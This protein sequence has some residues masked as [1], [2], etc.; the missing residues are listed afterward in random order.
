VEF[1]LPFLCLDFGGP[2]DAA[3]DV[4]SH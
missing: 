1:P 2:T 3:K 4:L